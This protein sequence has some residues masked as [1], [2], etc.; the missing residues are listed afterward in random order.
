MNIKQ[1]PFSLYDFLGYFTPGA[2][3]LY[4]LIAIRAH[5]DPEKYFIDYLRMYLGFDKPEL[6]IPFVILAYATGHILSFISSITVERY[7][8]WAFGYPSKYLLGLSH[9]GYFSTTEKPL[10]RGILRTLV[11]LFLIPISLWDKLLGQLA[12]FR[13]LYAKKLDNLLIDILRRKI[14]DLIKKHG[15]VADP[16]DHGS[17][18]DHDYFRYVYHFAIENAPNHFDKMQNYVALYGFLRTLTLISIF[19]SWALIW[20]FLDTPASKF[21]MIF[22]LFLSSVSSYVLFMGFTKFY[23]RFSLEALMAFAVS[24]NNSK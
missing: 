24:Y 20:H 14:M 2:I 18:T 11:W 7:S 12:G 23:R 5:I 13:D 1:N 3:F 21:I 6:Y 17:A 22:L 16:K 10:I 8:I 19:F 15:G 4:T 9:G